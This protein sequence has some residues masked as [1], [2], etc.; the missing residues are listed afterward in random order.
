MANATVALGAV[1]ALAFWVVG[2]NFGALFTNGATDVNSGPL[3]ML[4]SVAYW[5][6]SPRPDPD[7]AAEAALSLERA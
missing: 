1:M 6:W 3:L 4:L 5:R 7:I 2:E